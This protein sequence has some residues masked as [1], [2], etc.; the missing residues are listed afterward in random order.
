MYHEPDENV[1]W[2]K[3]GAFDGAHP[4]RSFAGTGSCAETILNADG[5][6][7]VCHAKEGD[8]AHR[9]PFVAPY[10]PEHPSPCRSGCTTKDHASYAECLQAASIQIGNLK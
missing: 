5:D 1:A 4:F 3:A 7:D 10:D 8:R 9:A 6:A 2:H